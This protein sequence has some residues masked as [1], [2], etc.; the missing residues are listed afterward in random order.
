[1]S[2]TLAW[3]RQV[4]SGDG[5]VEVHS[6]GVPAQGACRRRCDGRRG[7]T[8]CT[9][10][11]A[12]RAGQVAPELPE[13]LADRR[14]SEPRASIRDEERLGPGDRMDEI[15]DRVVLRLGSRLGARLL[16]GPPRPSGSSAQPAGPRAP[17]RS[18]TADPR[19]PSHLRLQAA[20]GM[21]RRGSGPRP[22]RRR[23]VD[24]PG[25]CQGQRHL[26]VPHRH[27]RAARPGRRPL[28]AVHL[29]DLGDPP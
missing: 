23:A 8:R 16:D 26:L 22:C 29:P 11:G 27:P 20:T 19:R 14:V 25:P 6:L 28:R 3:P 24:L 4:D 15:P 13:G 9:T 7:F 2:L 10:V 5:M 12:P 21:V 17:R 18:C 1:M